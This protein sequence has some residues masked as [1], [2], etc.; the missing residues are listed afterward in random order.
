MHTLAQSTMARNET[1]ED[2]MPP[3]SCGVGES[4]TFSDV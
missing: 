3:M 4:Y 1:I 2:R